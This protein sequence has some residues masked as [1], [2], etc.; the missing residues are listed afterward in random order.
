MSEEKFEGWVILELMG[1]K[2]LGGYLREQEIAGGVLLRLDIPAVD[3]KPGATQLYGLPAVYRITPT[4]EEV[5]TLC[6]RANEP[7]PIARWELPAPKPEDVDPMQHIRA[8]QE[9]LRSHGFDPGP[10]D[11]V[12][13]PKTA[14]ALREFQA[15]R[16]EADL[17]EVV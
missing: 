14:E 15:N 17:E 3:G 8:L 10:I 9:S 13:G 7:A 2:R 4:T 16:E 6:V 12:Y 11:G 5:A 1:H